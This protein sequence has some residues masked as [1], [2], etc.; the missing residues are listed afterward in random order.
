LSQPTVAA[1]V[2][3][4]N[5]LHELRDCLAALARLDP[6][7]DEIVIVD[8]SAGDARVAAEAARHGA[9]YVVEPRRGASRARNAGALATTQEVV[10]YTDDDA[11]PDPA[12]AGVHVDAFADPTIGATSGRVLALGSRGAPS[13]TGDEGDFGADRFRVDSET[14]NWFEL[15]NFGKIGIGANMAFRRALFDRGFRL[16]ERL[17]VGTSIP[18]CEEH[19]AF[20]DVVKLGFTTEYL[21]EAIVR[22]G[23]PAGRYGRERRLRVLAASVAYAIML[24]VEEPGA[25]RHI[26]SNAARTLRDGGRTPRYGGAVIDR[27]PADPMTIARGLALGPLLYLRSRRV[28]AHQSDILPVWGRK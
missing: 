17:G 14:P 23:V 7:A 18:G 24:A 19:R 5:R 2:C 26:L 20:F 10:L 9:Q 22:H 8:N 1:V 3:T 15:T 13:A 12:W 21:P 27:V 25:R 6:P 4:R 11:L 16:E 28:A